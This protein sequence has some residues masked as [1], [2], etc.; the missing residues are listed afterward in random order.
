MLF[1]SAFGGERR[2]SEPE[3][4]PNTARRLVEQGI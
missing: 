2:M 4:T 3:D 1:S